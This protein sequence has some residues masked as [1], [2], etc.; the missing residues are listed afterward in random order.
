M[1]LAP[2]ATDAPSTLRHLPLC[3]ATTWK[4]SP[5]GSSRNAEFAALLHTHWMA[6][7]T[8]AV[9]APWM[10]THLPLDRLTMAVGRVVSWAWA[11]EVTPRPSSTA[12]PE[13]R[14]R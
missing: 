14:P 9:E 2:E 10:F 13:A 12:R 5:Y 11:V 3:D 8:S 6:G 7:V 1:T 4:A